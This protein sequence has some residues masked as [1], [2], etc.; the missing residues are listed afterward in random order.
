MCCIFFVFARSNLLR[1]KLLLVLRGE[2]SVKVERNEEN[3]RFITR[4]VND[5]IYGADIE[6]YLNARV[7]IRFL[8]YKRKNRSGNKESSL[9]IA[10]GLQESSPLTATWE[11]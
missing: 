9:L 5:P 4:R 10:K 7:C 6:N 2:L 8:R 11:K 3:A 1:K